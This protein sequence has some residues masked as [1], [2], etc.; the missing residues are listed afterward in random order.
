MNHWCDSSYW[1][2]KWG[3]TWGGGASLTGINN[4]SVCLKVGVS[5]DDNLKQCVCTWPLSVC[6][7]FMF[8]LWLTVIQVFWS[9]STQFYFRPTNL[10]LLYNSLS[11]MNKV[12]LLKE[13]LILKH[14]F[15]PWSSKRHL[16][17]FLGWY[18]SA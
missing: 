10:S 9:N 18:N 12:L 11:L 2:S 3:H 1:R 7:I 16:L 8:V 4:C 5:P 6:H 13:V 15:W 17:E 14:G